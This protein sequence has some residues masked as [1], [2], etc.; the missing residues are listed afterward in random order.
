MLIKLIH[1]LEK[2][3]KLN[4]FANLLQMYDIFKI[5]IIAIYKLSAHVSHHQGCIGRE[6]ITIINNKVKG[7]IR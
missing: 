4:F 5:N 3:Q 1:N 7:K 6:F 2:K